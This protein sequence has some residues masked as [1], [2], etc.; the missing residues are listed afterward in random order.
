MKS[1]WQR[2]KL[3]IA[4]ICIGSMAFLV[5]LPIVPREQVARIIKASNQNT[6]VEVIQAEDEQ[7]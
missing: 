2:I 6:T 3:Y 1:I 7:S 4:I 5:G